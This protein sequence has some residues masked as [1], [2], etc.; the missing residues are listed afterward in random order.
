MRFTLPRLRGLSREVGPLAALLLLAFALTPRTVAAQQSSPD[1]TSPTPPVRDPQAASILTRAVTAMGGA[2]PA[3]SVATGTVTIVAGSTTENGDIRIITR[4]ADQSA[5]QIHL[6]GETDSVIYSR[7]QANE[8]VRGATK[9][10]SLELAA[11]SASPDFPLPILAAALNDADVSVQYVGQETLDTAATLHIRFWNTYAS[12]RGMEVLSEFTTKDLWVDATSGL[13]RKL[14]FERREGRGAAQH[15]RIEV[16][17]SN[18]QSIG[19]F[20][21]PHTIEKSW[22]GTPWAT[23]TVQNVAFQNGL[24]D[25]DFPIEA[26]TGALP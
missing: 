20:L 26:G 19:G 16:S 25:G 13:P 15:I 6:S 11:S 21:Y 3:D 4:G 10:S 8:V 7:G 22:N 12:K 5:E 23:I 2:P 18:W 9:V 1:P 24:G 17:Y 14:A